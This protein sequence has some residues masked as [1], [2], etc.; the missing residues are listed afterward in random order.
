MRSKKE[1]QAEIQRAEQESDAI[2]ERIRAFPAND[3]SEERARLIEELNLVMYYIYALR[4]V[5]GDSIENKAPGELISR[6]ALLHKIR[7]KQV[8]LGREIEEYNLRK[9]TWDRETVASVEQ[10]IKRREIYLKG[11][12]WASHIVMG[13]RIVPRWFQVVYLTYFTFVGIIIV[14]GFASLIIHVFQ[15]PSIGF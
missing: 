1:I 8:E 5:I 10:I 12:L 14:L 3:S 4:Y 7:E 15:L 2:N 9:P 13:G 6:S 11:L